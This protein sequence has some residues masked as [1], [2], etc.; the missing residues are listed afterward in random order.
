MSLSSIHSG[1]RTFLNRLQFPCKSI[2]VTKP[3]PLQ[4]ITAYYSEH[5]SGSTEDP[6]DLLQM[7]RGASLKGVEQ[8]LR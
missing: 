3:V 7:G 6:K 8:Q 2:F 5:A 1:K 4:P